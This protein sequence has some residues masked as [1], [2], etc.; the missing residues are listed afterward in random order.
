MG[1]V[2]KLSIAIVILGFA[3]L[4]LV[5]LLLRSVDARF[6]SLSYR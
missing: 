6:R 2:E 1:A 4:A 5:V 3:T